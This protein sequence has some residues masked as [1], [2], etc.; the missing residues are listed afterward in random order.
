MKNNKNTKIINSREIAKL[1][2]SVALNKFE[3]RFF[4]HILW[5]LKIEY[6]NF[7]TNSIIEPDNDLYKINFSFNNLKEW[8][9]K[10]GMWKQFK[11]SYTKIFTF[12]YQEKTLLEN[13][14]YKTTLIPFFQKAEFISGT[15][16]INLV[17]NP[18]LINHYIDIQK[19]F[20]M[21]DIKS[22]NQFHSK[23]TIP[24]YQKIKSK[25]SECTNVV[26]SLLEIRECLKLNG[27]YKTFTTLKERVLIPVQNDFIFTDLGN[28]KWEFI[29]KKNSKSIIA[30]KFKS[31][32]KDLK[33]LKQKSNQKDLK[34]L[35]E[36]QKKLE[37][38]N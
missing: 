24:L 19:D 33:A 37:L 22:I 21:L 6:Y 36:I 5:K 26:I 4:Y 34:A 29:K 8:V 18:A 9:D 23:Y 14:N 20:I 3:W 31:N 35:K 12:A 25:S 11:K 10:K 7:E 13:G 28:L 32:Q 17:F 16:D 15:L 38:L 1:N 2:Y 30:I 27:K